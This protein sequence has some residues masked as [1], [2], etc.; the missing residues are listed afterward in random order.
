MGDI[1]NIGGSAERTN[2]QVVE[3]ICTLLDEL[4]PDSPHLP[5]SSLITL[6]DDRPGHD[7]RYAID[8][9]KIQEELDWAPRETF[10]DGLCK[11]VDW[12]LANSEWWQ[13]ILDGTYRGQRLGLGR[14]A[15]NAIKK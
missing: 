7:K 2:I 5:H 1:Y 11:T 12:Y 9:T 6:V 10:S 15:E 8:S 13:R 3:S 14:T 4:V